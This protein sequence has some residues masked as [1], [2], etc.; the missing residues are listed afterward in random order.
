LVF[1][2]DE[3]Q[4]LFKLEKIDNPAY[5]PNTLSDILSMKK[6]DSPRYF[7]SM[8]I[9]VER[10]YGKKMQ[11][12]FTILDDNIDFSDFSDTLL[13]EFLENK[14]RDACIKITTGIFDIIYET[15]KV[16]C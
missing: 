2:G 12:H 4:A 1:K 11:N 7:K 8:K 5:S 15:Y 13:Y 16:E 3:Y 10:E 6:N 9:M 14:I